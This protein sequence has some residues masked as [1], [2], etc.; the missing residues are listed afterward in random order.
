LPDAAA[1]APLLGGL[2]VGGG[3]RRMGSPKA[4]IEVDGLSLAER[5]A[6]ALAPHVERVV[7]LGAGPVPA[8]LAGLA[9]LADAPLAPERQRGGAD[10][11]EGALSPSPAAD[12]AGH[13]ILR[14]SGGDAEDAPPG[15]GPLAALLAALR[16][17]PA[18]AWVLCPCDLPAVRPEAVAWL[19]AQRRPERRAVMARLG[20]AAPPEPLL[21]LYEPAI[22]PAVETLV[23]AGG[24]APRLL[25]GL[26]G[27]ALLTPPA[28]LADCWRDADRPQ[29]LAA[30]D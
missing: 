29:D 17:E 20:P 1:T 19:V 4:L 25:A 6:A 2:L 14:P 22:R 15:A 23:A 26:P 30:G 12:V 18:A 3:S 10:A 28:E 7:L 8:A 9:R 13:G 24:R 21:A 16:A 5:A 27:V 11:A